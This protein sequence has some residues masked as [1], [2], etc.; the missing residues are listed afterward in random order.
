MLIRAIAAESSP[1]GSREVMLLVGLAVALIVSRQLDRDG[2]RLVSRGLLGVGVVLAI[3]GW[4]GVVWRVTPWALPAE[5]LWRA[6]S[7]LTYANATAAVL[8]PVALTG[9]ALL[10]KRPRSLS[11]AVVVMVLLTGVAATM[12]RAGAL[13][14]V[15]GL[16]VL[17][18]ALR[19]NV[20]RGLVAPVAGAAV[21]FVGLLPSLP[22]TAEPRPWLAVGALGAGIALTLLL[23]L[24]L[25]PRAVTALVA[26]SL[27]VAA[28]LGVVVGPPPLRDASA[29]VWD[30]RASLASPNRSRAASAALRVVADHPLAGV[31]PG[32]VVAETT[33]SNGRV[34]VYQYVHNE[35][36]QVLAEL[37]AVGAVLLAALLLSLARLLWRSRSHHAEPELWAGVAAACAA[38][39]VQAAFDFV[40][41]VPAVPLT[42][43][44]LLGLAIVPAARENRRP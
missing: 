26:A 6:A 14:L 15:V 38:A 43:A 16:A 33:T 25:A 3:V 12:S 17:V 24:P 42:V 5:G 36:L 10:S 2:R 29:L 22:A 13:A 39:A 1:A 7:T 31:G 20:I 4:A 41:H 28:S 11:L 32:R 19:R 40:W 44:V 30:G 37:G 35:Y 21:A 18:I 27:V 8:V 34:Q 9:S 23:C